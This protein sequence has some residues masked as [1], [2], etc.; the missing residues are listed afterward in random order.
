LKYC[1]AQLLPDQ[2]MFCSLQDIL[3]H[4]LTSFMRYVTQIA[5]SSDFH[6]TDKC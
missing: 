2:N 3:Q 1:K 6:G 5:H 4:T